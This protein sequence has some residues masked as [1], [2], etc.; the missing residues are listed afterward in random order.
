[1]RNLVL[2]VSVLLFFVSCKNDENGSQEPV[3]AGQ[4]LY[5]NYMVS[6]EEGTDEVA[7]VFRF[8]KGG[9]NGDAI[10]LQAPARVELDGQPIR[11][12]SAGL[13]GVVYEVRKPVG[14]FAG[15]HRVSFIDARGKEYTEEFTF[16]PFTLK[17]ELPDQVSRSRFRIE[18]NGVEKGTRIRYVMMDTSVDSRGV[19]EVVTLNDGIIQPS[20][21][22]LERLKNGPVTLLLTLE[23]DRSLENATRRGGRISITYGLRRDFFLV[24]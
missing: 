9:K 19:N 14:G 5:Q 17:T 7:C 18:L 3:S 4:D 20:S 11:P 13:S 6:A 22:Q 8:H 1:M 21:R 2:P 15:I 12:D 23:E 10:L 16:S 24:N